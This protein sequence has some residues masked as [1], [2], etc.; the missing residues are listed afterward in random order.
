[1]IFLCVVGCIIG[2]WTFEK[3]D[4]ENINREESLW[5]D[6]NLEQLAQMNA[7]EIIFL[8]FL[9]VPLMN[10]PM[11]VLYV[12][13]FSRAF[14]AIFFCLESGTLEMNFAFVFGLLV[15]ILAEQVYICFMQAWPY[16]ARNNWISWSCSTCICSLAGW[17][18]WIGS[19][20]WLYNYREHLVALFYQ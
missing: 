9:I 10:L 15:Y 18:T 8:V 3:E 2:R 14:R 20:T 7:L 4:K 6:R 12:H 13:L 19:Q 11:T 5:I 1:M 17:S 16:F